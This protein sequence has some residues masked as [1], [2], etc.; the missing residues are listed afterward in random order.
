[1]GMGKATPA[2]IVGAVILG[3]SGLS[4]CGG[5][6]V[7]TAPAS[8]PSVPVSSPTAPATSTSPGAPPPS[9]SQ[10]ADASYGVFIG[11]DPENARVLYDYRTVVI[12]AAYFTKADLTALK[13]KG[14]RVYSYLNVGSIE[15]F[16]EG[17][18]EFKNK[19]LGKYEDWP[20]EYWMDVSLPAWQAYID[21]AAAA[22]VQKGV[23]GFFIDNTDVYYEYPKKSILNGLVTILTNLSAYHKDIL[24]NGGDVFVTEAVLKPAKPMVEITGVNQECLFT[25]INFDNDTFGTQTS[26]DHAY[27]KKY[28]DKVKAAGYAVYLTEYAAKNKTALR[29]KINDYCASQGYGCFI[30]TSLDL[31]R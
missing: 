3:L 2:L 15:S 31:D 26:E 7:P 4:G 14:I 29:K 23:D 27:Y 25:A 21:K 11:L 24:I 8:S 28:L 17:Y 12:D 30:A 20:G 13:K 10:T 5:Q 18:S 22:L 6:P 19:T 1:M 9:P 16:R